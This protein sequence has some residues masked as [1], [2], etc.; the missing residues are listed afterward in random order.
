M[1]RDAVKA[2]GGATSNVAVRDWILEHYPGTNPA[3]IQAQTV[4]CTVNHSSRIH[5]PENQKPRS[6]VSQY[7][8]LYRPERGKLEIYDPSHH[9]AWEIARTEDG[10]L[11]VRL[12]DQEIKGENGDGESKSFAAEAHLRDYLAHNLDVVEPGLQLFVDDNGADGVEYTTAV[13]RIDILA[14][15]NKNGLVVIELKVSRGPDAVCGQLLRYKSWVKR[16]LAHG[17]RVRGFI[18]A[19]YISERIRYAL[20]DAQDVYLKEYAVNI[21]LQDVPHLDDPP[22]SQ[23]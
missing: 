11:I 15:D 23:A 19:Q 21:T 14:V 20:A 10:A 8:F 5:Y 7:D 9:G 13:G 17:V 3:T 6:A 4:V 18:I 16:H 2:L 22:S 12:V 1:I